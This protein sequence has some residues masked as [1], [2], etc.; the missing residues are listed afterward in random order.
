MKTRVQETVPNSANSLSEFSKHTTI[1]SKPSAYDVFLCPIQV[2]GRWKRRRPEHAESS[3]RPARDSLDG[4]DSLPQTS[5]KK[6]Q[7]TSATA[8]LAETNPSHGI[9]DELAE[10]GNFH[11]SACALDSCLQ[12]HDVSRKTDQSMIEDVSRIAGRGKGRL[13]SI[14]TAVTRRSLYRVLQAEQTTMFSYR[15][16]ERESLF[17]PRDAE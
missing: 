11:D 17:S 1:K 14:D 5:K 6:K 8:T 7:A 3:A 9:L 4:E 16:I 12:K 15:D 10:L 2:T 13:G